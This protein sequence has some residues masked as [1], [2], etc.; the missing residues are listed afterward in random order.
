MAFIF[1]RGP[2]GQGAILIG[3]VAIMCNGCG[4]KE[5]DKYRESLIA[6]ESLPENWNEVAARARRG[7][8]SEDVDWLVQQLDSDLTVRC[9]QACIVLSRSRSASAVQA[10]LRFAL[11][12]SRGWEKSIAFYTLSR[13]DHPDALPALAK[14]YALEGYRNDWAE[15]VA[16]QMG[17]ELVPSDPWPPRSALRSVSER[18]REWWLSEGKKAF[19]TRFP[20]V[21]HQDDRMF[22]DI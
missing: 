11:T 15:A 1:K 18:I 7:L 16:R 5:R 6:G 17:T 19:F 9:E 2:L 10:V 3:M 12:D 22:G 21:P 14:C 4:S 20:D 8:T 13:M